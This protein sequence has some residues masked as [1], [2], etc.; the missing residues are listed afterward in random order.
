MFG[1]PTK[2][3]LRRLYVSKSFKTFVYFYTC[4]GRHFLLF[5]TISLKQDR[6]DVS[7]QDVVLLVFTQTESE[8]QVHGLNFQHPKITENYNIYIL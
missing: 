3:N 5:A 4:S 6:S 7:L 2:T 1:M 8:M